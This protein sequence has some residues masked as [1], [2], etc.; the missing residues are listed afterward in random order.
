MLPRDHTVLIHTLCRAPDHRLEIL[1]E[2]GRLEVRVELGGE[3]IAQVLGVF[4]VVVTPDAPGV[5]VFGEIARDEL[6]RV[7]GIGLTGLA[8]G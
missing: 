2:I 6:D 4:R 1:A 8:G 5:L 3:M 7:E